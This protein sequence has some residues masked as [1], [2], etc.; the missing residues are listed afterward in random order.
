[1]WLYYFY[2]IV[3]FAMLTAALQRLQYQKIPIVAI[4]ILILINT[5]GVIVDVLYL[6]G[7]HLFNSFSR[8]V[9]CLLMIGVSLYAFYDLLKHPD[10]NKFLGQSALFWLALG[11]LTYMAGNLFLFAVDNILLLQHNPAYDAIWDI[12]SIL[13]ILLNLF[14]IKSILCLTE[15]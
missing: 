12:H 11:V 3:E 13:N 7:L 8:S 2:T 6:S 4:G 1:M 10:T 9:E 14:F 5:A 15:E